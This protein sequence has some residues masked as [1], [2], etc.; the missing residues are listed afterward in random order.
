MSEPRQEPWF[1]T[2]TG[3][4]FYPL[5]PRPEDICIE[6]IAHSLALKCRFGGHCL[7]F[8]S[9]AEHSVNV[10]RYLP[11]PLKQ[12]GLMHDAGEAYLCDIIRPIK[13]LFPAAVEMEAVI[14]ECV[15]RKFDLP[16]LTPQDKAKLKRIDN[17]MLL[18]E[19]RDLMATPERRWDAIPV[20]PINI[21]I[22]GLQWPIAEIQFL[23]T[24]EYLF[25]E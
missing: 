5:D 4:T 21:P 11:D 25:N 12:W 19:A 1:Q 23:D 15:A 6:D 18:T 20:D 2:F 17:G 7:R 24:F 8:Y 22:N 16:P 14:M 10:S 3:R 9:V 13:S